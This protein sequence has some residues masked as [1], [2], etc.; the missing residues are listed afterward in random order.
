VGVGRPAEQRFGAVCFD[1]DG[2]LL[3]GTTVSIFTAERLGRTGELMGLEERYAAGEIP[4]SA[5]ADATARWFEGVP[6]AEVERWLEEAPWI[7]GVDGTLSVLKERGIRVVLGTVTWQFAAEA[8]RKR[9]GFEAVSGTEMGSAGA[10]LSGR[11]SRHFDEHD[12]LRFVEGYCRGLGVPMSRC[13]AVGDSRSDV[14]LFEKAG[15]AVAVNATPAARAAADLS[16]DTDDLRDVLPALLAPRAT[17]GTAG[18]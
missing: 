18:C 8:L 17:D 16:V 15:L 2:T 12:K 6:V 14:P 9:H 4:S 5:V 13:A 1:L 7:P 10:V 11:V 3:L